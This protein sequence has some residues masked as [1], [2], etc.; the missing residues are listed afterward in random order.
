MAHDP[1]SRIKINCDSTEQ[2][3]PFFCKNLINIHCVKIRVHQYAHFNRFF[4]Y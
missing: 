2:N 4:K 1:I 3:K